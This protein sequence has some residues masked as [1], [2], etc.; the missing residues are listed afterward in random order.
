MFQHKSGSSFALCFGEIIKITTSFNNP[1]GSI[2]HCMS[3]RN[4]HVM[5]V[6]VIC[7]D[8]K[9]FLRRTFETA[10]TQNVNHV[11]DFIGAGKKSALC[12]IQTRKQ[13]T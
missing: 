4:T 1:K 12:I 10:S 13:C 6:S 2:V 8:A 9:T 11:W 3:V 7:I 5:V